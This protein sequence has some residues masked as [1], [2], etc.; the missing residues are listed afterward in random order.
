[1]AI[2]RN[3]QKKPYLSPR[4]SVN[5]GTFPGRLA[6]FRKATPEIMEELKRHLKETLSNNP[7]EGGVQTSPEDEIRSLQTLAKTEVLA[8]P[9]FHRVVKD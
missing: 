7:V 8:L 4:F 3:L 5:G 9:R 2:Y 6:A 1:L